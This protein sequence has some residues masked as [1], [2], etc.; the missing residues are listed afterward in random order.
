MFSLNNDCASWAD[1]L[2]G[3]TSY[4]KLNGNLTTF[5]TVNQ[6]LTFG[7]PMQLNNAERSWCT[8]PHYQY[9]FIR[10]YPPFPGMLLETVSAL[11]LETGTD[12]QERSLPLETAPK[13]LFK[14]SSLPIPL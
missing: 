7:L 9:Q 13:N 2:S 12:T 11:G 4:A 3:P 6:K 5:T 14:K 1:Q 10:A 8:H